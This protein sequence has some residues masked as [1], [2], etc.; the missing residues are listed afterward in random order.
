DYMVAMTPDLRLRV[1][2]E[3]PIPAEPILMALEAAGYSV[4]GQRRKRGG[5]RHEMLAA[6]A[7]LHRRTRSRICSGSR[8]HLTVSE[9]D[10]ILAAIDRDDL[11]RELVGAYLDEK[12][13]Y[14]TRL[15]EELEDIYEQLW[16]GM[17]PTF[18]RGDEQQAL[19]DLHAL[20]SHW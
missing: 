14:T 15:D 5:P 13:A 11:Q 12:L 2:D 20:Y 3:R 8:T 16:M 10:A 17:H 1:E 19:D 7:G 4:R 6:R 18:P 9:A